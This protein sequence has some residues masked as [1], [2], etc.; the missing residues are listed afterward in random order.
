MQKSISRAKEFMFWPGM[1]SEVKDMVSRCPTCQK[2][3][4]QQQKEPLIPHAVPELPWNKVGMDIMEFQNKNY[5][6]V[7]DFYSH[8]PE[9]RL[10]HQK[11]GTDVILALKSIFAV[12]GVPAVV[13][14][15]NMPFSSAAMCDFAHEWGFT[16]TTSSPHYHQSNGMAERYVQIIKQ[17]LK[18]AADSGEDLYEALL[19]Y[20]QTP[21]T[22]L[23]FSPAE[24]LFNRC[25]RGPLPCTS[26][27]LKPVI[28]EALEALRARQRAQ[29][30]S[31]DRNAR[32]LGQL[33]EGNEVLVR[34]NKDSPWTPGQIVARHEQPRSYVV[35]NGT[36]LVRR[37]RIH[38]RP[39]QSC[40]DIPET[41][42]AVDDDQT[43]TSPTVAQ[44]TDVSP[45][46]RH[47]T[48]EHANPVTDAH[49]PRRSVRTTRGVLPKRFSEYQM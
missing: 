28:P 41:A 29:K 19:S 42:N 20:R 43:Q 30:V 26:D 32:P 12:H 18:K 49:T 7:V 33:A 1:T 22:G 14:A 40:S 21:L 48:R 46:S 35:D 44:P 4:N 5:L 36:S 27:H 38:L 8:Y 10:M 11:R 6:I 3:A 34:I 15:D 16:I 31:H 37:N 39:N 13:I 17:F 47:H 25:I 23:P 9:V 2:F 24:M 45:N